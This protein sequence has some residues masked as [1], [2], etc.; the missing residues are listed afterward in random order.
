MSET[1]GAAP[2]AKPRIVGVSIRQGTPKR[3]L[4]VKMPPYYKDTLA[5]ALG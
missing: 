5:T 4:K 2:D 3:S 1:C